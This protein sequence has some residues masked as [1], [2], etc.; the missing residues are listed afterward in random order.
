[1][2][3]I[4]LEQ[5]LLSGK[6]PTRTYG[7]TSVSTIADW[8]QKYVI[9]SGIYVKA[10]EY[11][12]CNFFPIQYTMAFN[13]PFMPESFQGPST[14]IGSISIYITLLEVIQEELHKYLIQQQIRPMK[15]VDKKV[16]ENKESYDTYWEVNRFVGFAI[17]SALDQATI[18]SENHL[19]L[20][21]MGSNSCYYG[22]E[23]HEKF[24]ST[25]DRVMDMGGLFYVSPT[26]FNFG[27]AITKMMSTFELEEMLSNEGPNCIINFRKRMFENIGIK[28]SFNQAVATCERNFTKETCDQVCEL[29]ILKCCNS[30]N[31]AQTG[32]FT[33]NIMMQ[34]CADINKLQFRQQLKTGKKENEYK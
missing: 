14:R 11:M 27:Y 15:D 30:Y 4:I 22:D 6:G 2:A 1:M 7:M 19:L 34:N 16:E 26:F 25:R 24:V 8:S 9:K 21:R 23:Y 3:G 33:S 20:Q 13:A 18:G 32:L 10:W 31:N 12:I 29:I 17:K 28:E 5:I